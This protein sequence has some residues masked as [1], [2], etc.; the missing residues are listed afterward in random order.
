L[1]QRTGS[2]PHPSRAPA[3]LPKYPRD[4]DAILKRHVH[5][6]GRTHNQPRR[7]RDRDSQGTP[8]HTLINRLQSSQSL[9][10]VISEN[11][12]VS[13]ADNAPPIRAIGTLTNRAA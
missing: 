12:G 6:R 7:D 13:A 8:A 5:H 9:R 4:E 2:A 3:L 1:K 10:A 11:A